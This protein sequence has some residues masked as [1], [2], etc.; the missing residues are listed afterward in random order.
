[1][2]VAVSINPTTAANVAIASPTFRSHEEFITPDRAQAILDTL[3]WRRQRDIRPSWV[4]KLKLAMLKNELT[5]L[6]LVFAELPGGTLVLVDGQHRLAALVAAAKPLHATVVVPQ[7]ATEQAL[8]ALYLQFD[9]PQARGPETH[10]KA[11]GVF[12]A[13]DVPS[14]FVRRMGGAVAMISSR[15]SRSYRAEYSAIDRTND[16][17][18][19]IPEIEA[20]YLIL[21]GVGP[22]VK[23]RLLRQAVAAV[24][25]VTLRYQPGMAEEFWTKVASQ[26]M[27]VADD[28]R[29][30]LY[31]WLDENTVSRNKRGLSEIAYGL[32]V[33]AAWNAFAEGRTLRLLKVGDTSAPV[34]LVGTPYQG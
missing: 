22:Q 10:L 5:F 26:E 33:A 28:P 13:T 3:N 34:R 2:S 21:S 16:V 29:R 27:L 14:M 20:Y 19:W 23:N 24:A 8:G 12:E 4:E 15:F 7:V 32:Y 6:S 18:T 31:L 17:R 9:R 11:L 30:R 1:M 25:L